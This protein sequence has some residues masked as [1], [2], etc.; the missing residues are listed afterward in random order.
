MLTESVIKV[1][2]TQLRT[3]RVLSKRWMRFHLR[4]KSASLTRS[5]S[6][7]G[8]SS[9]ACKFKVTRTQKTIHTISEKYVRKRK[10]E[11]AALEN[12]SG[13]GQCQPCYS[14]GETVCYNKGYTRYD[15]NWYV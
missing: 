5:R 8:E 11:H 4:L 7:L 9:S 6:C 15:N 12:V 13:P 2:C 3:A 10:F 14:N 1:S